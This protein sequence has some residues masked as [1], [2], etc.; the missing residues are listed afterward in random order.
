MAKDAP[1]Y[2]RQ[3]AATVIVENVP[4][5]P[6]EATEYVIDTFGKY[7][8]SSST[9]Q[10]LFNRTVPAG[11]KGILEEIEL[12]CDNYE[13]A[14]WYVVVKGVVILN[15]ETLPESFTKRFPMLEL[16]AAQQVLVQVKSNSLTTIN[17]WADVSYKEIG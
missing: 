4:L 11:R 6:S 10:D 15:S 13:V 5:I 9:L 8:G 7:G 12:S 3:F 1:D 17:A 14:Q 2:V 16:K